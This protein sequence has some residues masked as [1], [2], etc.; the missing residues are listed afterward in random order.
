MHPYAF[1]TAFYK[2]HRNTQKHATCF[3]GANRL[4]WSLGKNEVF[5]AAGTVGLGN[6]RLSDQ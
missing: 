6:V 1:A 5:G 4:G 2:R 3:T